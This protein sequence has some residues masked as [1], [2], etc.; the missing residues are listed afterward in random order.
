MAKWLKE[1]IEFIEK[2]LMKDP[3][4]VYKK[5]NK[6]INS[7]RSYK[8]FIYQFNKQTSEYEKEVKDLEDNLITSKEVFDEIIKQTKD[9]DIMVNLSKKCQIKEKLED[10]EQT[11]IA[12]KL[13]VK[14]VFEKIQK[15][16]KEKIQDINVKEIKDNVS[17]NL[18]VLNDKVKDTLN[19]MEKHSNELK[20]KI[21][22]V[23]DETI[24]LAGSIK[25]KVEDK[26]KV[27]EPKLDEIVETIKE[28][29][30]QLIDESNIFLK[31]LKKEGYSLVDSFKEKLEELKKSTE[32]R[33]NPKEKVEEKEFV[34]EKEDPIEE[35][36]KNF[37]K[38]VEETEV[39]EK[40]SNKEKDDTKMK[41]YKDFILEQKSKGM[42]TKDVLS[43]LHYNTNL[44]KK[45]NKVDLRQ[46]IKKHS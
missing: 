15:E 34:E 27:V 14:N 32:D 33:I 36:V 10:L 30:D 28:T 37:V 46:F 18:D 13:E 44:D 2:N 4:E 16:I 43:Y 6:K 35:Y 39:S 8:S 1:E 5:F 40:K 21:N 3:K 9:D 42:K 17:K 38:S 12:G 19:L 31:K 41:Y 25:T 24:T 29:S 11:L 26:V 45:I 20:P 22:E 7:D 23:I